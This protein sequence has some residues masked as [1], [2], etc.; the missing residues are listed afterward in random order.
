MAVNEQAHDSQ[1]HDSSAPS[2]IRWT[3]LLLTLIVGVVIWLIGPPAGIEPKAWH[4]LAIFVATIVGFI[5][6][7]LPMGSLSV[8]SMTLL[9][10]T[11]T[12]TTQETLAGFSNT[13]IWLIVAAFFISRGFI[14]TG[15]GTRIAYLFVRLFGKKTLGL[16]YSLILCDFILAPATPSNTARAGGIIFPIVRSLAEAFGSRPGDGTERKV[17]SFLTLTCFQGNM[18]TSA[19][20]MTAMAANPLAVSF[21]KAAGIEI[22]WGGWLLAALLPGIISLIVIPLFIY[23][24]Y[25]PEIKET[26]GARQMAIDKLK[27]LGP[28]KRSEKNMIFVFFIILLLWIFGEKISIDA[29]ATA[30]IGLSLL[31]AT[32]VL[33]WED[34]KNEK[35]AWDTLIW[36]AAL[37]MMATQ[38][39]TLGLIPWVSQQISQSVSG[40]SWLTALIVLGAGYYYVHYLFAS[41][42]AHVSAMYPAF[43][44]VAIHAGAPGM[45]AALLFGFFGNLFGSTTHYGAGPAPVLFGS[46]YVS[47]GKW[48]SIGF[49]ISILHMIIWFG[50]GMIWWK[51]LGFY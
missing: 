21:A 31:L 22:T 17:G 25:G 24:V 33:N 23:K 36:F 32:N 35:A 41:S 48:W 29:T 37:V 9:I 7:P 49:C 1:T 38:L 3:P 39:N 46:G 30:L 14:K 13:T 19:M 34:I 2:D 43:L 5:C 10:I 45:L 44:A 4:L 26:P 40:M 42:T 51:L 47:Q 50:A 28:V 12:L 27:E 15:L 6:K 20:F 16:S 18:I 11:G 8:I